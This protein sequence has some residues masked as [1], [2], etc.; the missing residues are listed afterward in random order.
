MTASPVLIGF[1]EKAG[2]YRAREGWRWGERERESEKEG[3]V[4]GEGLEKDGGIIGW[5]R[6]GE[7]SVKW[8]K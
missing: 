5:K 6:N 3:H 7:E 2:V 8:G 4:R 1:V